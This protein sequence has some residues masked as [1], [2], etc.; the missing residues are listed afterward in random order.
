MLECFVE[1]KDGGFPVVGEQGLNGTQ[2]PGREITSEE[3][4]RDDVDRRMLGASPDVDVRTAMPF[5]GVEVQA[6]PGDRGPS[7]A[8]RAPKKP[9]RASCSIVADAS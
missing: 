4:A 7:R 5:G 3:L 9:C 2:D 1:G 8:H 6:V